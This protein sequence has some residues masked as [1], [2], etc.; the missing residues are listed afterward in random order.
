VNLS[1]LQS[2]YDSLNARLEEEAEI[3]SNLRNQLSKVSADYAS[4]KMRFDKELAAKTEELEET[5]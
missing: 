1:A 5:R 2:D 4:L 3:S